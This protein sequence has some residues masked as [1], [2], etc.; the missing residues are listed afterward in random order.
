MEEG[1][2]R[3]HRDGIF[4]MARNIPAGIV[5]GV[6]EKRARAGDVLFRLHGINLVLGF[7]ALVGNGQKADAVDNGVGRA[8]PGNRETRVVPGNINGIS[9]EKEDGERGDDAENQAGA[10]RSAVGRVRHGVRLRS[11][12]ASGEDLEE[13]QIEWFDSIVS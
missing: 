7:V 2:K 6:R 1:R 9:N 8:E 10:G 3:L 4:G 11:Y 5:R 13:A 12:F